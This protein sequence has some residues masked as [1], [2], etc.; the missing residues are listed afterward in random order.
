MTWDKLQKQA[1]KCADDLILFNDRALQIEGLIDEWHVKRNEEI[2][3]IRQ[4][5]AG[6]VNQI[7]KI[8]KYNGIKRKIVF[9][10]REKE[11]IWKAI[12]NYK[13]SQNGSK[14]STAT[15]TK[16]GDSQDQ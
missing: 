2:K 4:K 13:P 9:L 5:Y 1:K 3:K 6:K 7:V 12:V 10:E 15:A 16:K 11:V 8:N 14:V